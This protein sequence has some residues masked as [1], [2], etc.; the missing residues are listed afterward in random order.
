MTTVKV[1]APEAS[2]LMQSLAAGHRMP[3]SSYAGG[4]SRPTFLSVFSVTLPGLYSFTEALWV[5]CR[6][7][8]MAQGRVILFLTAALLSMVLG[9]SNQTCQDVQPPGSEYSCQ[10]QV[11][12]LSLPPRLLSAHTATH[13]KSAGFVLL[14]QEAWGKC[15]DAFMLA[16]GEGV[17]SYCAATCGRC[18]TASAPLGGCI[19]P[20]LGRPFHSL[21]A[22]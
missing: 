1:A 6:L 10:Q 7:A 2:E 11:W 20:V 19:T 3:I 13:L 4:Y 21:Q 16:A 17:S 14:V 22:D 9:Q 8:S 5:S 15:N 12:Q 18:P